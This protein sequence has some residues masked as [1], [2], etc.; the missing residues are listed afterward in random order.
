MCTSQ[1][2]PTHHRT[3][4]H[5]FVYRELVRQRRLGI[6][7][8]R[9]RFHRAGQRERISWRRVAAGRG[10]APAGNR[11]RR[12]TTRAGSSCSAAMRSDRPRSSSLARSRMPTCLRHGID[13]G[14]QRHSARQRW[15]DQS[16]LGGADRRHQRCVRRHQQHR[17]HRRQRRGDC[18]VLRRHHPERHAAGQQGGLAPPARPCSWARS[19]APAAAPAAATSS[20]RATCDR[21]TARQRSPMTT[22]SASASAQASTS[23]WAAQRRARNSI[24]CTYRDNC[25]WAAR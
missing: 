15:L 4:Q 19:P 2:R 20:S 12:A 24:N 21:A 22:T 13:H 8:Y 23:N 11:C 7:F 14:A 25:R 1:R 10:A 3:D 9:Q 16:R 5:Q 18:H 6:E 17:Q